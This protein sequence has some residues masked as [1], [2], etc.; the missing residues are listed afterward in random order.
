MVGNIFP[1]TLGHPKS[2]QKQYLNVWNHFNPPMPD[3][4][5]AQ[6]WY[7]FSILEISN[8]LG[9]QNVFPKLHEP[10]WFSIFCFFLKFF[11]FVPYYHF[12][13]IIRS[14]N[15][16]TITF[17]AVVRCFSSTVKRVPKI[18]FGLVLFLFLVC[19]EMV[20]ILC[21]N[22]APKVFKKMLRKFSK[23]GAIKSPNY[24]C[25]LVRGGLPPFLIHS[26][27]KS[28]SRIS[29]PRFLVR[30]VSSSLQNIHSYTKVY[31]KHLP[32]IETIAKHKDCRSKTD[33][34]HVLN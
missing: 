23:R 6:S 9:F 16:E 17:L 12:F 13:E 24:V 34:A 32:E 5:S 4:K 11:F 18:R 26:R 22:K 14:Q 15:S 33:F 27:S 3:S 31:G 10:S 28:D 20:R 7:F 1:I 30:P 25:F 21:M 29:A 2:H 8:F 19:L